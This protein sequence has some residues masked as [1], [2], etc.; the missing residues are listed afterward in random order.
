M[1]TNQSVLFNQFVSAAGVG[2]MLNWL[3]SGHG[4]RMDQKV[5]VACIKILTHCLYQDTNT[6]PV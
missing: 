2:F 4:Q 6:L 3:M 1:T 5:L